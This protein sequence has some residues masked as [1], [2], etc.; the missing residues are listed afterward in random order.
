MMVRSDL[1]KT[2]AF[3]S[4]LEGSAKMY[5]AASPTKFSVPSARI[6]KTSSAS[7]M[8]IGA[9]VEQLMLTPFRISLTGSSSSVYAAIWPSLNEPVIL[10]VPPNK[11]VALLPL[12]VTG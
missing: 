12:T 5:V 6:M 9:L 10:Y 11:I 3:G 7:M 4:L 2:A 8:L 1:Q